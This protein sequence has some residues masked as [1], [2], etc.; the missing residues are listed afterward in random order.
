MNSQKNSL[1][2]LVYSR[3]DILKVSFKTCNR[4]LW[5]V[6]IF[7]I[8]QKFEVASKMLARYGGLE[9]LICG[10]FHMR[11]LVSGP[12]NEAKDKY[13]VWFNP[14]LKRAYIFV[15]VTSYLPGLIHRNANFDVN[16]PKSREALSLRSTIGWHTRNFS[17]IVWIL[18]RWDL[19]QEIE[20]QS[21]DDGYPAFF[22]PET[23]IGATEFSLW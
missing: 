10:I 19:A 3:V 14:R 17:W 11:N 18:I 6:A 20:S 2:I 12:H 15:A 4:K 21:I 22:E 8:R 7:C 23:E 13:N 9:M 5:A 16:F 1:K